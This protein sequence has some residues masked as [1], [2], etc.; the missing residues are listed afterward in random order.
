[1]NDDVRT[2]II[3]RSV[4]TFESLI[5]LLAAFDQAS[6][7]D[8]SSSNDGYNSSQNQ[9]SCPNV[10]GELLFRTEKILEDV[11]TSQTFF[12]GTFN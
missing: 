6:P 4:K 8:S 3:I 9:G 12:V 1:M 10:H 7:S 11:N 5:V 2:A